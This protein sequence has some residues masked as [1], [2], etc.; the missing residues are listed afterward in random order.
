[1]KTPNKSSHLAL[2][3]A[4]SVATAMLA[5]PAAATNGYFANGYGNESKA[6]AG[7]GV[8]VNNGTLGLAQNPAMG[9]EV[10]NRADACLTFFSP[11]R[12]FTVGGAAPLTPGTYKSRNSLF[13]I[14]CVGA[15]WQLNEG[16]TIGISIFG[17]GGMNTEYGA[18]P[19]AGLGAGSVPLGVNLEQLFIAANYAFDVSESLTLG[20]APTFAVQRFSATGLEAFAGFSSNPARV[21]N[22]GDDW[23]TGFGVNIGMAWRPTSEWTIGA[24]YRTKMNMSKFDRYA[25]LYAEQGDFDIPATATIGA[26]YTPAANPAWTLT[27]EYQRIFYGDIPSIANS[28]AILAT[29]LG[30]NNGP[31][32]GWTD[33]NVFRIAGI[34]R[35][36]PKLTLRGGLSYASD[37]LK[38][39]NEVLFNVLAPATPKLHASIGASY[40]ISDKME[41][42]GAFTH[43]FN[44]TVSGNNLTPGFGQPV[45]LRMDQ[46]ELS[47]GLSYKW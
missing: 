46:N 23:S 33:M 47:L 7:S 6:M 39:T 42:T 40:Q 17:N 41:L 25:G 19:F 36:S 43:V 15:N 44:N 38:S 28:N 3:A 5:G 29:P 30:A 1:M 10:G 24:S 11:D 8:A 31:G 21:T 22:Q 37:F 32:F 2:M 18:N 27:A 34:Y 45:S 14:P 35:A 20:I 9:T 12:S 26:A 16:S 13:L 4:A